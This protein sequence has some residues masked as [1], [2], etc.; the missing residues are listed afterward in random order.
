M[1]ARLAAITGATGFLGRHLVRAV[2][3]LGYDVRILARRDPI[4]PMWRG[5]EPDVVPGSL[6]D[7][8]ALEPL[9]EGASVVIHAAGLIK[10]RSAQ[11]L[12]EVNAA[13]VERIAQA[14]AAAGA[15]HFVLISSLAAREA[16]LSDYAASKREGE[17]FAQSILGER[18]TVIRPPAV[19]G[20]GDR[21]T[22]E[23]FATAQRLGR[24][25][26]FD[27]AARLALIHVEDAAAQ[28][29]A[30]AHTQSEVGRIVAL[31]DARPEGYAWDEIA[32]A[33]GRA[34]GREVRILP[35]PPAILS[36]IGFAADA[37]RRF[38]ASTILSSGKAREIRHAD[39]SVSPA[40]RASAP[41]AVKFGLDDGFRH[42]VDWYRQAGWLK[43]HS[44]LL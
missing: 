44:K 22:L 38:G 17:R 30:L 6:Q 37:A 43:S 21:E 29:A 11:A 41:P 18:L 34:V 1:V 23:L 27:S 9:C 16:Q 4:D 31:S 42:T 15:A 32:A 8:A 33:A 12:H 24:L 39:W 5:L 25:P 2:A 7:C 13:G 36:V 35:L 26:V 40:E 3:A 10:A 20:P 19:Y 28:I 14:A